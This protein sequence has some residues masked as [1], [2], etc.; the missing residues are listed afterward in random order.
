LSASDIEPLDHQAVHGSGEIVAFAGESLE[1][2]SPKARWENEEG[3][4]NESR[5]RDT[6]GEHECAA[7][8]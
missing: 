3:K 5:K 7:H 2:S 4:Q 8:N 6:P 1:F